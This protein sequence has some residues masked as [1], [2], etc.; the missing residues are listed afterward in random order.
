MFDKKE[1]ESIE[2]PEDFL[3]PELSE[4]QEKLEILSDKHKKIVAD[5]SDWLILHRNYK[6]YDID[7]EFKVE[8]IMPL[9]K[10]VEHGEIVFD[11]SG[12]TQNL[13]VPIDLKNTGGEIVKQI[14]KLQYKS[15]YKAF[16]LNNYTKGINL[17][18]DMNLY[19]D[20]Q[21]GML[22]GLSRSI[23]GKL[24]DS[25]HSLTRVIQTLYFL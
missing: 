16:E 6:D 14:S 9:L 24:Y 20:A 4:N 10:F 21:V 5:I 3:D 11:E 13:R 12:I 25:D 18:K 19:M 15:R 2:I 8:K 1:K 7:S 23:I 17:A 22:V